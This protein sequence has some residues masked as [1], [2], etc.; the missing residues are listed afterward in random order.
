M[1]LDQYEVIVV[2]NGSVDGSVDL[3]RHQFPEVRVVEAGRNLGFAGGA[4]L[5]WQH[6]GGRV[7][8][9]LNQD[10]EPQP[11]WLASLTSALDDQQ[12]GVVGSKILEQDGIT[13]QHAG[14]YFEWPVVE[15]EHFGRGERDLGQYDQASDVDFVTG[16]ALAVRRDVLDQIGPMDE[17]FFPGYYE[18]VDLC[19]RARQ[20]GYRVVYQPSAVV[21]HRESSSFSEVPQGRGPIVLRSRLRYILK[22]CSPDLFAGEFVPSEIARLPEMGEEQIRSLALACTEAQILWPSLTRARTQPVSDEDVSLVIDA[23]LSLHRKV[24]RRQ[25][26]LMNV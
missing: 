21:L 18:D 5:G 13:L 11:G 3:V 1:P 25:L 19:L 16:A 20:A 15:G 10:T 7:L 2:D 8:A 26:A 9:L 23:L 6:S 4:N 14:G 24:A 22:N 17:G 12:I